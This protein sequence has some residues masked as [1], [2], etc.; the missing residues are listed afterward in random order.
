MD[1]RAVLRRFD[2]N[3]Q[4]EFLTRG[5]AVDHSP[6]LVYRVRNVGLRDIYPPDESDFGYINYEILKEDEGEA[7]NKIITGIL[8]AKKDGRLDRLV[9]R[10]LADFNLNPYLQSCTE[11]MSSRFGVNFNYDVMK[12]AE[13]E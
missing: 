12:A 13:K 3:M 11:S 5:F 1:L 6:D 7:K 8:I 4:I 2:E 9:Q 10:C